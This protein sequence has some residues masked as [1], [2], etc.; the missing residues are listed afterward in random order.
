[1]ALSLCLSVCLFLC[2]SLSPVKFVESFATWQHLA[3]NGGFSHRLRY[4]RFSLEIF[5]V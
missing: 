2:I 5:S 1:M 4:T 3:A